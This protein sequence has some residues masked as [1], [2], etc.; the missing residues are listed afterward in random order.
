MSFSFKLETECGKIVS[1]YLLK[2]SEK[3][4]IPIDELKNIWSGKDKETVSDSEQSRPKRLLRSVNNTNSDDELCREK[5]VNCTKVELHAL[6]KKY[7]KKVSGK[8]NDLLERLLSSDEENNT[9]VK[10]GNTKNKVS[11]KVDIPVIK[12]I[13][14]KI[15]TI[16]IRRNKYNNYEHSDSKLLFNSDKKVYGKQNDDGTV[17]GLTDED[18]NMCN[19]YKFSYIMPENLDK[20]NGVEVSVNDNELEELE[21]DE[22][23]EAIIMGGEVAVE[24]NDEKV[25]VDEEDEEVV[26]VEDEEVVVEDE[27]VVVEDEE[28]VVE[29]EEEEE[30]EVVEEEEEEVVVEDEEEEVVVNDD[31]ESDY[32]EVYEETDED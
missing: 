24:E 13:K 32:E 31:E 21:E 29:D 4:N 20:D 5:L 1:S 9:R 11:S 3:Y 15:P 6:C 25:V 28:V 14:S 17:D 7:N 26:D 19:A 16:L 8:K 30:E 18:I 10:S 12:N 2:I 23:D 27:E 22:E